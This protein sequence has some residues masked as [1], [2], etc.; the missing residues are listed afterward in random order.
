MQHLLTR[1]GDENIQ[2][3]V[4]V[5]ENLASKCN[6]TIRRNG[7]NGKEFIVTP[8]YTIES[9]LVDIEQWESQNSINEEVLQ[10]TKRNKTANSDTLDF[11][12]RI[13]FGQMDNQKISRW[14]KVMHTIHLI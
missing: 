1:K 8:N 14:L 10:Q 7:S 9:N 11:E 3:G 4:F 2:I 5:E 12:M 13:L 6:F